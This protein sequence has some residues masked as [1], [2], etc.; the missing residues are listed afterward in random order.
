METAR[1]FRKFKKEPFIFSIILLA[2]T[3]SVFAFLYNRINQNKK[4]SDETEMKW[5]AESNRREEIKSLERLIKEV[6]E[7]RVALESHFARSS[8]AVPFLDLL[9]KLALSVSAKPEI[10]SVDVAKDKTGLLVEVGT[11]GTF[12]AVYKYLLLLENSPY[13]LEFISVDL[14]KISEQGTDWRGNF[15][16]KLLSFI[17]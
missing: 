6:E 15:K 17:P 10:V 16:M 9:E 2:I 4:V 5:Q 11:I 3:L 12:E 13:Q 1:S 7:K 8:N 14:H